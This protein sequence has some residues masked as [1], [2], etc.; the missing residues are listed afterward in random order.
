MLACEG[1]D[2][3]IIQLI[4]DANTWMEQRVTEDVIAPGA[5]KQFLGNSALHFACRA[6]HI[7][8]AEWLLERGVS[9]RAP[10]RYSG[11][12]PFHMACASSNVELIQWLAQQPEVDVHAVVKGDDLVRTDWVGQNALHIAC[13][14]GNGSIHLCQALLALGVD[15][16]QA[17][18]GGYGITPLHN[19][20]YYGM[21]EAM[22]E[23]LLQPRMENAVFRHVKV[24]DVGKGLDTWVGTTALYFAAQRQNA[25]CV[26]LLLQH[27]SVKGYENGLHLTRWSDGSTALHAAVRGG[28]V[29]IV[30]MLAEVGAR[31]WEPQHGGTG[32]TP[33]MTVWKTWK[34]LLHRACVSAPQSPLCALQRRLPFGVTSLLSSICSRSCRKSR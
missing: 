24:L 10:S 6:G 23:M 31:V 32:T 1:G 14:L 3:D 29:D 27:A 15:V 21:E 12:L 7:R 30:E 25:A 8:A 17:A 22:R 19:C 28:R 33:L 13:A 26:K 11:L 20:A 4:V 2:L 9:V 34:P 5:S 16:Q 18:V